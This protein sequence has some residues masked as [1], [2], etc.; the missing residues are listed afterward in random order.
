MSINWCLVFKLF[1]KLFEF[2]LNE[3][4]CQ[5]FKF[6]L[7]ILFK[8]QVDIEKNLHRIILLLGEAGTQ[9]LKTNWCVV[10][11]LFQEMLEFYT[12]VWKCQNFK[13]HFMVLF[14]VQVN[15]AEGFHWIIC[16][17]KEKNCYLVLKLFHAIFEF[18]K[19]RAELSKFQISFHD[20]SQSICKY[21]KIL[22]HWDIVIL[23]YCVS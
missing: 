6:S 20:F 9:F 21:C 23:R 5:N 1:H 22:W 13:F 10:L 16:K 19:K 2:H 17:V 15:I 7:T 12:K 14:K 8:V 18:H 11:K 4:K 3:H